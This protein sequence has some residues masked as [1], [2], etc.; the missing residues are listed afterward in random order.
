M[1]KIYFVHGSNYSQHPATVDVGG[2]ES[3][4]L[5]N[6]LVV[7]LVPEDGVGAAIQLPIINPTNENTSLFYLGNKITVTFEQA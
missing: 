1:K 7:E 4:A 5:F 2:Q 6:A 3:V